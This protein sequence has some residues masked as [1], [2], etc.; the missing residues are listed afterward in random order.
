M[1]RKSG[2]KMRTR[3]AENLGAF[4]QMRNVGVQRG[5]PL[6]RFD[7]K[8]YRFR[9]NAGLRLTLRFSSSKSFSTLRRRQPLMLRALLVNADRMPAVPA[10]CFAIIATARPI[11]FLE[12]GPS[13]RTR[14]RNVFHAGPPASRRRH[15]RTAQ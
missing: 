4:A 11:A 13:S 8:Y 10:R 3:P 14:R 7:Q 5:K 12:A 6:A 9:Y 1:R 2:N 15:R